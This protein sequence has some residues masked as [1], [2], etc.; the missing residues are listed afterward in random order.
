[1]S[2]FLVATSVLEVMAKRAI[3]SRRASRRLALS[4]MGGGQAMVLWYRWKLGV[5]DE[6]LAVAEETGAEVLDMMKVFSS[7]ECDREGESQ[8]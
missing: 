1:M 4:V 8:Q 2:V 5:A 7:R 3:R 6:G